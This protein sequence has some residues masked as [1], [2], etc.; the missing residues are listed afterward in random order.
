LTFSYGR[1]LQASTLKENLKAAPEEYIKQALVNRLACQ[2]KY[3][4]VASLEPQPVNLS[5]SLTMPTNQSCSKAASSTL[6]ALAYPLAIEEDKL[7]S[8]FL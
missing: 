7:C 3:T 6:Q 5:S 2:G 1:A 8:V 4:P